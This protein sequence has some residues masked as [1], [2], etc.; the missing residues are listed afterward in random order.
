LMYTSWWMQLLYKARWFTSMIWW[1]KRYL[2]KH[3]NLGRVV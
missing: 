3:S 2:S 1:R